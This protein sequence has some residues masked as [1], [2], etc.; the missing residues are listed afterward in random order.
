M[1]RVNP[2]DYSKLQDRQIDAIITEK[3]YG[4]SSDLDIQRLFKRGKFDFC[5][6]PSNAWPIIFENGIE[7]SPVFDGEWCASYIDS[8]TFTNTMQVVHKNPLRAAMV[9][10]LSILTQ[11]KEQ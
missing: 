4:I 5:N 7:L 8:Y 11:A 1:N 9:V 3:R 6:N 2:T 10:Y